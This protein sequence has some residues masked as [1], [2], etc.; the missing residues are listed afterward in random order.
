MLTYQSIRTIAL[1]FPETDEHPHFE[2][3]SFRV[4]KKIFA[5]LNMPMRRC[6]LKFDHEYQDI[7]SALGKGKI[8]PVPNAWGKTGWTTIELKDV[9]KEFFKDALLIAWR[10]TA[11]KKFKKMY[12]EWY[13]DED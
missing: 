8:Y 12:P 7:F 11:P 1:S 4:N 9:K 2:L 3:I 10:L 5:T 6:T 13:K